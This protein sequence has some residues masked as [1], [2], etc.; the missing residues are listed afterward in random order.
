MY[1][2][3]AKDTQSAA[4][5]EQPGKGGEI[6]YEDGGRRLDQDHAFR[7]RTK[8]NKPGVAN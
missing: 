2:D 4:Q 5:Y 8:A 7:E 3:V 6:K 1:S